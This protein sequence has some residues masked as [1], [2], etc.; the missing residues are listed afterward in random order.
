M[1]RPLAAGTA[2]T[3]PRRRP[4]RFPSRPLLGAGCTGRV[5]PLVQN[6]RAP[7]GAHRRPPSSTT[8]GRIFSRECRARSILFQQFFTKP[9][10]SV[11]PF[12]CREPNM[13]Y[14]DWRFF[15]VFDQVDPTMA[16]S[17]WDDTRLGA[18]LVLVCPLP[19]LVGPSVSRRV[20]AAQ[21]P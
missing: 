2:A 5:T 18:L 11:A 3:S 14:L 16:Y 1:S 4:T 10:H 17:G 12:P 8:I 19:G 6:A 15:P 9:R 20:F 7:A 21:K 13:L